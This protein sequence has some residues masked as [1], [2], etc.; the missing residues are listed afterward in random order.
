MPTSN[1]FSI[2]G[3]NIVTAGGIRSGAILI[4]QE[5]IVGV[6]PLSAIPSR[7]A[8]EDVGDLVVL[9]GLVD[10]H[11]HINE[12]GRT[13]W[14]GFE[15]ATKS[16]AAGGITTLIDMPLNSTPVT[17]TVVALEEK[18]SAARGRL[19][20]DCGFYAGL[21]PGN[22][23]NIEPLINAGIFGV[24]AFLTHSGI[25]DFPNTTEKELRAAMPVLAKYKIPLLVHAELGKGEK[26]ISSTKMY[27][28]YQSSRPR[29]WEHDAIEMMIRLCTE[30]NCRTHIVHLSSS[31]EVTML[32]EAR[33]S[34][35][36]L[37]VE[38]CPH[39]LFF[40]SEEITDGATQ[41]K[42]APPIREGENR[43]RLWE[44]LR[45]GIIDMIVSDH[46]PCPPE[47]KCLQE[48]DFMK[49]W[50]G[51]SSLQFGLSIIWTEAKQKG[52]TFSDVA[53]WM[54]SAPASLVGL[55]HSKGSIA[56]GYDADILVFNPEKAFIV[57]RQLIHHRHKLTPYE[58]RPLYGTTERTYV[59]GSLV[60]DH[61][62][63][64]GDPVGDI[65]F[66]P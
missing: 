44:S 30:Y 5:K 15:T 8:I 53:R 37:T 59:R 11:V 12:P 50:G 17:T 65:L 63:F 64:I 58:G 7:F 40:S 14:E 45:A 48:G 38:T 54:S 23:N 28:E 66:R 49:A 20:V 42:C 2:C 3:N 52:C 51:I 31:D 18:I 47:L 41:Y 29:M 55:E 62:K 34:G 61:G 4:E 39:Y 10:T 36:P 21:V 24:K 56:A 22:E 6:V 35:L 27:A 25:D 19:F 60:F 1:P 26:K 43:K 33:E 32:A 13:D 9:P 16:A 46:S 57:S